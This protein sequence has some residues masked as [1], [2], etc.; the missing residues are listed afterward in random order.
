MQEIQSTRYK[1]VIAQ[2]SSQKL[3]DTSILQQTTQWEATV[4]QCSVSWN[5]NVNR[6]KEHSNQRHPVTQTGDINTV[7]PFSNTTQFRRPAAKRRQLVQEI[8]FYALLS[9]RRCSQMLQV[10]HHVKCDNMLNVSTYDMRQ[11]QKCI[12]L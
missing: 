8:L 4:K 6:R 12:N 9:I 11:H 10:L 2:N 1:S 7:T 3:A 5:V